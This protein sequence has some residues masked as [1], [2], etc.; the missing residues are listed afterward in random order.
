MK[1]IL[2]IILAIMM[3][4]TV[5]AKLPKISAECACVIE[6]DSG[7]L[8]YEK[9]ADTKHAMAS[10][11]KIMTAIVALETCS[12]DEIVDVSINASNTEGS[13][14]YIEAGEKIRMEDLVYGLMLNSGNDA[15]VAIA[16]HISGNSEAFCVLMNDKAKQIGAFN[17]SFKNPNGLFED[18]HYTTASDLAK[19]TQYALKNDVFKNIVSTKNASAEIIGTS[20]KLYF[21][22]H[23]KLLWD[24]KGAIGVKTGY[25][26]D[27]G[28]C[29]VSAAERDGCTIIAVT[30]DAPSDWNDHQKLLDFG[31][32][33]VEPR[34]IIEENQVLRSFKIEDKYYDFLAARS[35]TLFMKKG[36]LGATVSINLPESL[37]APLN[38]GEKVGTVTVTYGNSFTDTIDIISAEP[39]YKT[40][41]KKMSLL[42]KV[43]NF[44]KNIFA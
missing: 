34:I 36:S 13:S 2:F 43:I 11:T 29:L 39:I 26:K 17:T 7:T 21:K 4:K 19:I 25:T 35:C 31:F 44:L 23:N 22:N 33:M 1:K 38:K 10:T 42:D 28:R 12:P 37:K 3:S 18:N 16:E 20:R 32:S 6:A 5:Y 27:T 14:I 40:E 30:L 41:D 15:A 8:L 24:Y 9:N